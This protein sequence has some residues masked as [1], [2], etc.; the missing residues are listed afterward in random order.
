VRARLIGWRFPSSNKTRNEVQSVVGADPV[1]VLLCEQSIS[2]PI[3][4]ND[5][6]MSCLPQ[7]PK[8]HSL[9]AEVLR[10]G[11]ATLSYLHG[12][13]RLRHAK[14]LIPAPLETSWEHYRGRIL[15]GPESPP[16]R[17]SCAAASAIRLPR[18]QD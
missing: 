8:P 13:P 1:I 14:I 3:C 2:G 9:A 12:L 7:V 16:D 5:L 4:C 6:R 18:R 10:S 11:D 17:C 15:S